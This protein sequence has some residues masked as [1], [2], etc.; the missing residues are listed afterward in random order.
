MKGDDALAMQRAMFEPLRRPVYDSGY[1]LFDLQ[2]STSVATA[3]P[4]DAKS[5]SSWMP[6][7]F[8]VPDLARMMQHF[9]AYQWPASRLAFVTKLIETSRKADERF[10]KVRPTLVLRFGRPGLRLTPEKIRTLTN[11]LVI[12]RMPRRGLV[13]EIDR[14]RI[15]LGAVVPSMVWIANRLHRV[16]IDA[17]VRARGR[18]THEGRGMRQWNVP[19]SPD[20]VR[21]T[22]LSAHRIDA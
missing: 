13:V 6:L 5:L 3:F 12:K 11:N 14:A 4:L 10:P 15:P 20:D 9:V 22:K 21:G 16:G 7:A 18:A 8:E 19:P 17:T 2:L 1:V